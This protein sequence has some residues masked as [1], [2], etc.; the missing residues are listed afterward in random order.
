VIVVDDPISYEHAGLEYLHKACSPAFVHRDVKTSNILLNGNLEAKIADFG[1]LKAFR[2]EDDTHVSTDRVV[3]THGYLA[4]E[5]AAALQ[6]TEKSDVYSFGVVL[7]EVI[8]GRPP[9]LRCPE[10][11]SVAQ[12][13][14]QRLARGD[15]E[16]VVD[17]ACRAAATRPAPRGR[18]PTSTW[19]RGC[20]SASSSRK[21]AADH[22]VQTKAEQWRIFREG[23]TRPASRHYLFYEKRHY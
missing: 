16:D 20:R 10:P 21:V 3:G 2:R 6:L 18:P 5:Y 19:W 17:V 9:I 4:P 1:L 15:I 12:W 23:A 7:L 14:R 11:T 13:A 8:T 22:F